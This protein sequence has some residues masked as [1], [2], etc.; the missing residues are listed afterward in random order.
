MATTTTPE[1]QTTNEANTTRRKSGPRT[2][3]GESFSLVL[4]KTTGFYELLFEGRQFPIRFVPPAALTVLT[5]PLAGGLTHKSGRHSFTLNFAGSQ[6]DR[7]VSIYNQQVV[8][9]FEPG[10][11]PLTETVQV[12]IESELANW[13]RVIT[14]LS[15]VQALRTK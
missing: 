4:N 1:T 12:S 11:A 5:N 7:L 15:V 14:E 9:G 6:G 3:E 8:G 13:I 10:K 2:F